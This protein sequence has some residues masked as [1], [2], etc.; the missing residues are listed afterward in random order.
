M[1][2]QTS[3]FS[4]KIRKTGHTRS[5]FPMIDPARLRVTVFPLSGHEL[6]REHVPHPACSTRVSV[7][8]PL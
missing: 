7:S 6:R 2:K 5:D 1:R 8:W 4:L 3:G